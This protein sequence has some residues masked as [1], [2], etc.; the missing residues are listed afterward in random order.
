MKQHIKRA[1]LALAAIGGL[2]TVAPGASSPVSAEILGCS[3]TNLDATGARSGS[4]DWGRSS[5][6]RHRI[7]VFC[8][9]ATTVYGPPV[10]WLG[11][12]SARCG[13][14][15]MR[16]GRN[17]QYCENYYQSPTTSYCSTGWYNG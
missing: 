12:S 6:N 9:N 8:A 1:L 7:R 15:S 3:I 10:T 14:G 17:I 13:G 5:A 11:T 16:V 4:C 2:I